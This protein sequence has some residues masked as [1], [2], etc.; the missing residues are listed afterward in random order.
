MSDS[1]NGDEQLAGTVKL[2]R[3]HVVVLTAEAD[4]P[5]HLDQADGLPGAL[6]A[7]VAD[8]GDRLREV[9]VTAA[10]GNTAARGHDVLVFPDMVRYCAGGGGA[11]GCRHCRAGG[12]PPG[13][14]QGLDSP[15][16]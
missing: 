4:W 13:R 12:G 10:T 5:S 16:Q 15:G 8:Q 7:A 9:K 1:Q 6:L 14:W 2:Y 11:S 3:R